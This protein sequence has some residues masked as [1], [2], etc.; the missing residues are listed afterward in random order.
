MKNILHLIET[1]GPGGA[2][3]MLINLVESLVP[4]DYTSIIGLMKDGWLSRILSDLGYETLILP[5]TRSIDFEF[6]RNLISVIKRKN[7]DVLHAHEFAMNV[8]G[9][10]ASAVTGVP[11][12]T[13]V[14]G[15][16]YYGERLRRRLAY[17]FVSRQSKMVAVSNDIADYLMK[18]IGIC[19]KNIM[20][21]HNGVR[22][23]GFRK[24]GSARNRIRE[25]LGLSDDQPLLGT[26]GNLYPVKG[27]I[28]LIKAIAIIKKIVPDVKTVIAGRGELLDRLKE[29]VSGL[30][31]EKNIE[32]LGYREDIPQL[33]QAM[34]IFILPSLSE[35][36][37]LS[38][39]EAMASQKPVVATDVGG[40][41]E[42]VEDGETGFLVPSED[43]ESLA[44]KILFILKNRELSEKMAMEARKKVVEEYDLNNMVKR[45]VHLYES[46]SKP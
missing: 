4:G 41:S 29:E 45:Y 3:K 18:T 31:L 44:E 24:D 15:K 20:T 26:V 14:H 8:Y 25:M 46:F 7:I 9:S 39:L 23:D 32:F 11:I 13:T 6:A 36:T 40:L 17:R 22:I 16:N 33:L 27:H 2:E 5:H 21:I 28:Y 10:M 12:V 34:D 1:S 42:I 30:G 38:I 35:G 43:P 19:A 37:P